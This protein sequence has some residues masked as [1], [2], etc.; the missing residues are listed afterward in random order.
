MLPVIVHD[1]E[2][3][4]KVIIMMFNSILKNPI[5]MFIN[6]AV[7]F[8]IIRPDSSYTWKKSKTESIGI[9]W[10]DIDLLLPLIGQRN[11]HFVLRSYFDSYC[12][13]P[14]CCLKTTVHIKAHAKT[15]VLKHFGH[16]RMS[17]YAMI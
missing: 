7:R 5:T 9:L 1:S 10:R 13:L 4:Q 12:F 6:V 3:S 8:V 15:V 16:L 17:L 14:C 2:A 11:E